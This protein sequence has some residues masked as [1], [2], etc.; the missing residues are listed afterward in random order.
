M[1]LPDKV[2]IVTGGAHGMGRAISQ[3]FAD[4]GCSIAVVDILADQA[5]STADLVC[6]KGG[7]AIA[8]PCDITDSSQVQDMVEKAVSKFGKV[9][10]LIN[11]AGVAGPAKALEDY[12]KEEW[13]RTLDVNLSGASRLEYAGENVVLGTIDV[14][15][16]S[17]LTKK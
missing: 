10:I 8:L 5:S 1:L 11:A 7:K 4:E 6:K 16:A 3:K 12:S 13:L 9:D 2:A 17:E 14:S 15:G